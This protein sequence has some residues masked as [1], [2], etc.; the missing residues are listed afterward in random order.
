[1]EPKKK[2]KGRKSLT[3]IPNPNPN[4][5]VGLPVGST[6]SPTSLEGSFLRSSNTPFH[7]MQMGSTTG[8]APP[9]PRV[10]SCLR[11][12]IPGPTSSNLGNP[13]QPK[14]DLVRTFEEVKV[15][16]NVCGSDKRKRRK[17]RRA[18]ASAALAQPSTS[19]GSGKRGSAEGNIKTPVQRSEA[20]A[21]QPE[22]QP[23]K[24]K[25]TEPSTKRT[26][27]PGSTPDDTLRVA[28]RP[29]HATTPRSQT[30]GTMCN[31]S[32]KLRAGNIRKLSSAGGCFPSEPNQH[33]LHGGTA[34]RVSRCCANGNPKHVNGRKLAPNTV[35]LNVAVEGAIAGHC[36]KCRDEGMAPQ[37]TDRQWRTN[38]AL[39]F[40]VTKALISWDPPS[41]A[42][43]PSTKCPKDQQMET[44][45]SVEDESTPAGG[46]ERQPTAKKCHTAGEAPETET[47]LD[48]EDVTLTEV[49][50][51]SLPT[52]SSQETGSQDVTGSP[53]SPRQTEGQKH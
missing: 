48:P 6:S 21:G 5:P 20:K 51:D 18:A 10:G 31:W 17:A 45:V 52:G 39:F 43:D 30:N 14:P 44:T 29:R 2:S 25:A 28:K 53:G 7:P 4:T 27:T 12:A 47:L 41:S 38:G 49:D 19:T 50:Q 36:I 24:E 40:G 16:T 32:M 23:S 34:D 13:E 33:G 35:C 3:T 15:K 11:S 26:R 37:E 46:V 42:T 9:P 8:S 1:M 22:A